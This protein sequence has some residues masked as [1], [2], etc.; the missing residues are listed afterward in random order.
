[1]T[2]CLTFIR[3]F[4]I[5]HVFCGLNRWTELKTDE[6]K[7]FLFAL[8]SFLEGLNMRNDYSLM[9]SPGLVMKCSQNNFPN[10]F[11]IFLS[12]KQYLPSYKFVIRYIKMAAVIQ[13]NSLTSSFFRQMD[14]DYIQLKCNYLIPYQQ[15]HDMHLFSN[16]IGDVL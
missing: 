2:N 1:M 5:A 9:L 10:Y 15:R 6:W 3:F 14:Q 12:S 4:N 11:T 7:A 8:R 16:C 13:I